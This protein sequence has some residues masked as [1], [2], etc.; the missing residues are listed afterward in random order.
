MTRGLYWLVEYGNQ[1]IW[2]GAAAET[3][4][5]WSRIVVIEKRVAGILERSALD[6]EKL[7]APKDLWEQSKNKELDEW[8]EQRDRE[9][10]RDS[11]KLKDW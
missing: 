2:K 9:R 3:P 8:F 6:F 4:W 5:W 1:P 10:E 11:K 7:V